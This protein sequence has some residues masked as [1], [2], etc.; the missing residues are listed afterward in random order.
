MKIPQPLFGR[1]KEN[2]LL[3][4]EEVR[5]ALKLREDRYYT[6]SIWPEETAGEARENNNVRVVKAK[7]ISK[8]G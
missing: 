1:Y 5:A 8:S 7:K 3:Y 6:V 2:P 4:D